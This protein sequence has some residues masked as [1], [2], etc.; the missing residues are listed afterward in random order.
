M[1][2]G[3]CYYPEHWPEAQWESDARRMAEM[4]ITHV[5]IAEFAWSRM[6][7]DQGRYDWSW[8]DRAIGILADAGLKLVLGTPTAAPPQWL[9]KAYPDVLPFRADGGQWKFGSRRHYDVSNPQY[10]RECTRIVT[11][12]AQRYGR[13]PAVV[14]WQTDNE[15]ACHDTVPSYSPAALA[16]FHAWLTERYGE[17]DTLNRAWGNVFWSMEYR[18]F[19]QIGF[20]V[21]T[22]TD[23]NPIHLL[24]FRRFLSAEVVSFHQLQA[25][26]IREYAPGRDLLHNFMGFFGAFDHYEFA[27]AGLDVAAWDSYPLARTEVLPF[28]EAEKARWARTGHPDVSAFSHDLYRGVGKGRFWVMEQQAGPVN[29]GPWNPTPA[30]G[31]VRLWAW[32]GLAHGAE[33]VSWFRWRQAPFAQEHLHSGLNL[34]CDGLSPGGEEAARVGR[35]L[36]RFPIAPVTAKAQVALV[37]DYESLWLFDI[38][39][40]GKTFDYQMLVFD[41]YRTLRQLGLDIDILPRDADFSGY[42]LVVVPSLAVM[43]DAMVERVRQSDAQ[44]VFGP[45]TGSRTRDFAI[46]A[47]LPPG[48]L[49]ALLPIQVMEVE[50]LR[51]TLTPSIWLAG[52]AGTAV[53]WREHVRATGNVPSE[54]QILAAFDDNWPAILGHR[55]VQYAAACFEPRLHLAW[56]EQTA[57]TAGLTTQRLP[58]G[59]RL[60]RRGDV[61]FAFNYGEQRCEVPA[62]ADAKFV[63]GGAVIDQ[64]QVSAWRA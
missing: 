48:P 51:P 12:M 46:P 49:Q 9:I 32:E 10:L 45:R 62:P 24:D 7:P 19:E 52:E 56:L 13:H 61:T 41:Y 54:V 23:A 30:P 42:K 3:V 55:N 18:S 53:Q 22:P 35:E 44:W 2:V 57:R 39:R 40:H 11:A 1:Q 59:L 20:P 36:E 60:R 43:D 17:I 15:L 5:R 29:W 28:S 34:P 8:L 50:S 38:Q 58:D 16:R 47:T 37:F 25:Q 6:E 27:K 14:A 33:L 21:Q 4:G 63:L 26:I 64:G 31:M